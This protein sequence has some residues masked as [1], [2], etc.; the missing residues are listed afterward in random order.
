M[1]F[2]LHADHIC[3]WIR[4]RPI[5]TLFIVKKLIPNVSWIQDSSFSINTV[6]IKTPNDI[7]KFGYDR[8]INIEVI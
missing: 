2:Y 8:M 3:F 5:P 6:S 1:C 7:R 4:P